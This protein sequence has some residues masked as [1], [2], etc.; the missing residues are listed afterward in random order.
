MGGLP[1]LVDRKAILRFATVPVAPN[2]LAAFDSQIRQL[3][4]S[5][6]ISQAIVNDTDDAEGVCAILGQAEFSQADRQS[7]MATLNKLWPGY[8]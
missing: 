4:A 8:S 1:C 7:L 3:Y 2:D 6:N 5:P